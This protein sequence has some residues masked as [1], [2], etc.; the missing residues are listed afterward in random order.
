[1]VTAP[2]SLS[3]D[4]ALGAAFAWRVHA[5]LES[6]GSSADR[7]AGILL[8]FQGGAFVLAA[9]E[10]S[11]RFPGLISSAMVLLLGAMAAGGLVVAPTLGPSARVAADSTLNLIY[12]GHLR[13]WSP[14]A[15]AGELRRVS[16][17]DELAML[18]RQLVALSRLRWRKHRLLQVSV[19]LTGLAMALGATYLLRGG[20]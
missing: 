8:T 20:H 16:A 15:L 4:R 11:P 5:A 1:M 19:L 7:K 14:A 6:W 17:D 2:P 18:S 13:C 3:P 9:T 10:T 12:F